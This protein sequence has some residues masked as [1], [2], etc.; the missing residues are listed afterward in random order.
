V[1][2]DEGRAV[3]LKG[4]VWKQ[5]YGRMLN[6]GR[7]GK[8]NAPKSRTTESK[9]K[10]GPKKVAQKKRRLRRLLH[11]ISIELGVREKREDYI[12]RVDWGVKLGRGFKGVTLMASSYKE[13][14]G[15]DGKALFI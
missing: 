14:A 6:D 8:R 13:R 9:R 2:T 15:K 12:S 5:S 3:Y 11:E 1:R 7:E 4:L 10:C